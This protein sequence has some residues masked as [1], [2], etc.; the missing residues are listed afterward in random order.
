MDCSVRSRQCQ[1]RRR[2]CRSNRAVAVQRPT[3]VRRAE[4]QSRAH[5]R[6]SDDSAGDVKEMLE[7]GCRRGEVADVRTCPPGLVKRSAVGPRRTF[8]RS[9][10]RPSQTASPT[11]ESTSSRKTA[12]GFGMSDTPIVRPRRPTTTNTGHSLIPRSRRFRRFTT[13]P[14][15][16]A[17]IRKRI[18]AIRLSRDYHYS[19]LLPT[20]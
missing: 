8:G 6:E 17:T 4:V 18:T 15:T 1:R 13:A 11:T 5:S 16:C 19:R 7:L 12:S 14:T 20:V 3:T 2:P 9:S 10:G